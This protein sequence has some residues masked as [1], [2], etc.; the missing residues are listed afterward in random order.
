V[1]WP[2]E[3]AMKITINVG[4]TNYPTVKITMVFTT[5]SSIKPATIEIVG[6]T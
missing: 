2:F 3:L 6:V 1:Q 5:I 4:S